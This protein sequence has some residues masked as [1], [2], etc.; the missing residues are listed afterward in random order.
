M[1]LKSY[2]DKHL[3]EAGC[4]EAGR[5]CLAGPVVAAAAAKRLEN[6]WRSRTSCCSSSMLRMDTLG[7]EPRASRMLSGCGT[8]TPT[9]LDYWR[10][11]MG[12]RLRCWLGLQQS[13]ALCCNSQR[14]CSSSL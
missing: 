4:D 7:I 14:V 10:C 6:F 12:R 2:W 5:G 9:A 8:I 11:S 3:I 1:P 13:T